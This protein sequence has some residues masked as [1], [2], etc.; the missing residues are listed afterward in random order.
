MSH[1]VNIQHDDVID[2]LHTHR[3]SENR[4]DDQGEK[5]NFESR[6]WAD[7][8]SYQSEMEIKMGK[9]KDK[10]INS[11]VEYRQTNSPIKIIN[12]SVHLY[13]RRL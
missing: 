13:E 12:F 5:K 9:G 2:V 8:T 11:L 4:F 6:N 3:G 10:P 7:G 1:N